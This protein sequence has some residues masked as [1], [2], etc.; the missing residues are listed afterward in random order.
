MTDMIN[1]PPH[2][3]SGDA[4]CGYCKTAIE[5]IDVTEPMNFNLG[6][7]TKYIWRSGYKGSQLA[8]LQKAVWYLNREIS[9]I[10]GK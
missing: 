1:H 7:A 10:E 5:C 3:T 4:K 8:D 9:R 2:Y 6:N